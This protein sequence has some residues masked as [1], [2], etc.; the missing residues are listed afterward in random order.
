[1]VLRLDDFNKILSK[2]II[3]NSDITA[4]NPFEMQR[5]F[6]LSQDSL[7]KHLI[8]NERKILD[9]LYLIRDLNFDKLL[10]GYNEV[11][12]GLKDSILQKII[13]NKSSNNNIIEL[14]NLALINGCELIPIISNTCMSELNNYGGIIGIKWFVYTQSD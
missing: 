1:M 10:F 9:D 13:Y 8:N 3:Y 14:E 12:Q 2:H 4:V 7:H 5:L 11:I 6:N